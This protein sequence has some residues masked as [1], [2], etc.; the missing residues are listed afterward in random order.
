MD[1]MRLESKFT[2]GLVS[3]IARTVVRKKLGY[4]MDIRLNRL[5]TTVVDEKTPVHL[6]RG[7]ITGAFVFLPQIPQVLLWRGIQRATKRGW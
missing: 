3:K 4:D 2:T 6:D 7:P 5:R 1:E